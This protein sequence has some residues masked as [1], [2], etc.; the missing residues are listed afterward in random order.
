MR[1]M[2]LIP[3]TD[4][5]DGRP[6]V[7]VEFI[8][9]ESP[10]AAEAI[11]ENLANDAD[12]LMDLTVEGWRDEGY[13]KGLRDA[14]LLRAYGVAFGSIEVWE[15]ETYRW[16]EESPFEPCELNPSQRRLAEPASI[17]LPPPPVRG[18]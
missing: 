2:L 9:V 11:A 3:W 18:G 8:E 6:R 13:L 10:K 5:A 15:G 1:L 4:L 16:Y 12:K 14:D 17:P 7:C